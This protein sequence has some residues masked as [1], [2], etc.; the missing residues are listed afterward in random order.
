M[1]E[2]DLSISALQSPDSPLLLIYLPIL[3][4]LSLHL[5]SQIS[6]PG[7]RQVFYPLL[8]YNILQS[9]FIHNNWNQDVSSSILLSLKS[10]GIFVITIWSSMMIY[11]FG[12]HR[13]TIGGFKGPLRFII[14]K[15]F[16]V[17][18]DLKGQV[19]LLCS[20]HRLVS[21]PLSCPF[22]KV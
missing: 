13:L 9:R 14:S 21:D 4:G 7:S 12:F 19:S 17:P 15:W 1:Y 6:E 8:L 22:S 20:F 5:I 18:V 2:L 10:T 3:A 11:R 16:M